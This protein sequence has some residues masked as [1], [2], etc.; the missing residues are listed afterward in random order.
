[1][2][3]KTESQKIK[4]KGRV[5]RILFILKEIKKSKMAKSFMVNVVSMYQMIYE[6]LDSE[7]LLYIRFTAFC[8]SAPH[9]F[10]PE[11][12]S[13]GRQLF[14]QAGHWNTSLL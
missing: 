8:I 11:P 12:F 14:M 5:T 4:Q 2:P 7:L 10:L 1:M 9:D 13:M 6:T 3:R